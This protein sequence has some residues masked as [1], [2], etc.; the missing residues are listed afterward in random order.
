MALINNS[1]YT[2]LL[3]NIGIDNTID[4]KFITISKILEKVRGGIILSD[5]SIGEDFGEVIEAE[6]LS[7][8]PLCN[9]NIN[10]I[11]YLKVLGLVQFLET[12][13][14]SFQIV[15]QFFMKMMMYF[16]C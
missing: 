10:E 1:S 4:P 15:K 12:T 14:L 16:F 3:T 8:S 13:K 6:I 11:I 9:K 5:Y 7:N 2:S